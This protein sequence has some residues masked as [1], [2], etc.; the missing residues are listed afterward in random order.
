MVVPDHIQGTFSHLPARSPQLVELRAQRENQADRR[1]VDRGKWA[2]HA[3]VRE[4][5]VRGKV[6]SHEV[7]PVPGPL[8]KNLGTGTNAKDGHIPR[9]NRMSFLVS[10]PTGSY[11]GLSRLVLH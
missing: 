6:L 7:E 5:V 1:L 10:R 9:E 4:P 3:L 11:S 8:S 2:V